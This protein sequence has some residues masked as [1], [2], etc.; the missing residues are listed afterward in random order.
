[1]TYHRD[2]NIVVASI[3][4]ALL[5][6]VTFSAALAQESDILE[7]DVQRNFLLARG[8]E[9]PPATQAPVSNEQRCRELALKIFTYRDALHNGAEM[10][11]AGDMIDQAAQLG[12][13]TQI[14][15]GLEC[16]GERLLPD[17]I[18]VEGDDKRYYVG[19][20]SR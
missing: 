9:I 8:I 19:R 13:T 10:L 16:S 11:E 15:L 3:F 17:D 7:G 18:Y 2:R 20:R 6:T 5:T 12:V 1:M 14:Y 4:G